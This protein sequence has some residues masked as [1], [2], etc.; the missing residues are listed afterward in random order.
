MFPILTQHFMMKYLLILLLSQ[1]SIQAQEYS[2]ALAQKTFLYV[3]N[4]VNVSFYEET[5][6]G[7][8]WNEMKSIYEV[9]VKKAKSNKELRAILNEML[10]ELKLSHFGVS[11]KPSKRN[12]DDHPAA[13]YLGLDLRIINQEVIV[14]DVEK[15]SPASLAGIKPGMI[16]TSFEGKPMST[17]IDDLELNSKSTRISRLYK[18]QSL[19]EKLATPPDGKTTLKTAHSKKIFDFKPGVYQGE[20][21]TIG[22]SSTPFFFENRLIGKDKTVRL[23]AFNIFIPQLMPRL[24]KAIAQAQKEQA[25]GLIIDLRGNL[26]GFGVMATGIIGRLIEKELDLGDMNNPSGNVPF[27]AFPQKGAY[28]GPIAVLVD[29]FSASTSEIFAAALQEHQ[30]ARI[31]GRPT[32]GAVLPSVMDKLPNGDIFQYA[33]GDF[34]TALNKTHL[35]GKGVTPDETISLDPALLRTGTDPDL[36]AALNWLKKQTNKK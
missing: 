29:S 17:F 36:R 1:L 13:S 31:F 35:E 8:D 21:A 14:F 30:R 6:N 27:H 5:F 11:K 4:K 34:V 15:N 2:P 3:W 9:R 12:K 18:T 26:G 20:R 22:Y 19:L 28:L 16:L 23:V 32:I 33:I 25:S 10:D 24:N 7:V